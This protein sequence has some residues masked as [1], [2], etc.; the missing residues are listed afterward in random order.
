MSV[1]MRRRRVLKG[2][3]KPILSISASQPTTVTLVW[4]AARSPAP[5]TNYLVYRDGALIATVGNVLTYQDTGRTGDTL[6]SY[7][8]YARDV[9]NKLSPVSNVARLYTPINITNADFSGGLTGWA[10][11]NAPQTF[12]VTGGRG[13][14][15]HNA[16]GGGFGAFYPFVLNRVY[17][18]SFDYEIVSGTFTFNKVGMPS[19]SGFTG[20]GIKSHSFQ[21]QDTDGASRVFQWN[22]SG[23]AS[24][25]WYIDNVR[26]QGVVQ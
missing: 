25:N 6:Y 8:V 7:T 22:C 13:H 2:I 24:H 3:G 17:Q 14:V 20:T 26:F 18:V 4:T 11:V 19:Q 9:N 1:A 12:E 16:S 10:A 15:L 21:Y 5:I 23:V